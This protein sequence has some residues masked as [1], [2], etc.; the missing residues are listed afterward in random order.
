M[1]ARRRPVAELR[2]HVGRSDLRQVSLVREWPAGPSVEVLWLE[3]VEIGEWRRRLE[4]D[5]YR[6]RV[7]YE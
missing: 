3:P 4:L 5:G 6:V 2:V 1:S 7:M